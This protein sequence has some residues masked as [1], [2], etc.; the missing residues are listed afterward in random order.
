MLPT[1]GNAFN[2]LQLYYGDIHNHCNLSYGRGTLDEALDNARLQLD[3]ASVTVHGHWADMPVD[4]PR[5]G[6]LVDYHQRGFQKAS[7]AWQNYLEAMDAANCD[8]HFVT[9]PSFEWHSMQYGDHC[10]YF[11]DIASQEIFHVADIEE[12]RAALR[13]HPHPSFM[14]PHHVGYRQGFRGMNWRHFTSEFSPV[15]EIMSFHGAS[16]H[17]D[18]M[19]AYLHA[20]GPRDAASTV[21]YALEQGHVFGFIGSSDHHGAHPGTYG[22]GQVAVWAQ[23]LSR[24][25]IWEAIAK[26]RTYAITGDHIRLEFALN[27]RP[28]GAVIPAASERWIEVAV[29]AGSSLDYIEVLHNNR[30]IQ[31]ETVYQQAL[32]A[33]RPMKVLLEMGWGEAETLT[34]WELDVWIEG[35]TLLGVEPHLRGHDI[36]APPDVD[37]NVPCVLSHLDNTERNRVRL[38]TRSP[39]NPTVTSSATQSLTLTLSGGANTEIHANING[40]HVALPVTALEKGARSYYLSGFVSPCFVFH[41]AVPQA[42][43]KHR[44]ALA[45]HAT[46]EQADWYYVRVRQYNGQYAWSSPIWVEPGNS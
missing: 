12:L 6:Y 38:K 3:F 43:Y 33:S 32:D 7:A 2:H 21:Q 17:S 45:H 14:I 16:E 24:G 39:R 36:T 29:E 4:D 34:D 40:I 18:A 11:R 26:R 19:P 1:L 42:E 22:Y 41:R 13:Q 20:M 15:V 25:S 28:M 5:L 9:F 30:V 31:R 27:G 10:V 8:G 23:D 35:G 44:F 46:G 37:E